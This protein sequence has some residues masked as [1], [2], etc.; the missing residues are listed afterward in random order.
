MF[1]SRAWRLI[2]NGIGSAARNMAVDETLL[3]GFG[4]NDRPVLRLYEWKPSLSFGRFQA[5][6]ELIDLEKAEAAGIACVRR[7]TGGGIMAHGGDLSYALVVPRTMLEGRGVRENYRLLCA[8]LIRLYDRLGLEAAFV[9]DKGHPQSAS[10][11]CAAGS[12]A[13]D[14]VIGG[15]KVGGNAQRYAR[16]VL[17]QHGSIPL[18]SDAASFDA[19]L[20]TEAAL[21][22]AATLEALG[23]AFETKTVRTHLKEAFCEAFATELEPVPL[24]ADETRRAEALMT[25]KYSQEAWNR[26]ARRS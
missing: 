15:R 22:D 23:A 5:P 14:V 4:Q 10:P 1:S 20:K 6:H 7:M 12:E 19:F 9:R 25:R 16:G 17:F 26:D 2:E 11:V 8:F 24:H 3:Y 13:Y 18:T 21:G